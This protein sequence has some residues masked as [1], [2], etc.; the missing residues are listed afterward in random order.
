MENRQ[1]RKTKARRSRWLAAATCAV[2]FGLAAEPSPAQDGSGTLP[3]VPL[4]QLSDRNFGALGQAALAIRAADWRH[5]E[6]KNFIYHYFHSYVAGPVTAEAEFYYGVIAKDLEKETAQWERKSHIYI[7]EK[8]EEWAQFQAKGSLDPWTGGLHAG[9][10]LFIVRKPEY[11]WQS[12]TLGHEVA[13]LVV[14]R[15]FGNGVPLWLN[16]GY[17]EYAASRGY[18]AFH[19]ARGYAPKP[20]A[21]ALPPGQFIPLAQLTAA[22]AYPR[23]TLE[24]A[25]F[26]AESERLARFLSGIDKRGFGVFFD[27]LSKGNRFDTA[28]AKGFGTRFSGLEALEGEF[29]A[30]ASKSHDAA[31]AILP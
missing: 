18:A 11:K 9:G 13:H 2:L 23:E 27:A 22:A 6:T 28:L 5:A 14:H 24:V 17:A 30:S 25:T 31:A 29:K 7:F 12:D 8:P 1:A 4:A 20:R 10:E 19:R 26:Y 3:E 15:F 21:R 16:E